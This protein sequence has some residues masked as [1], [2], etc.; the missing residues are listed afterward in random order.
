MVLDYWWIVRWERKLGNEIS[1]PFYTCDFRC[2]GYTMIL[3]IPTPGPVEFL[4]FQNLYI[5]I[6]EPIQEVPQ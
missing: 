1:P 5:H 3:F 4:D 2:D 6:P